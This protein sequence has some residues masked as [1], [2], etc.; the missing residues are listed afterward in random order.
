[1]NDL[2]LIMTQKWIASFMNGYEAWIDVRRTGYPVLPIPED[3]LNNDVFPVRYA[4]PSTEQAVNGANYS[5][6]VSA[7]GGD[8]FNSKGWWEN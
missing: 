2:E 5:Q 6:A 3:N 8:N 1:M 4:Y 7:I